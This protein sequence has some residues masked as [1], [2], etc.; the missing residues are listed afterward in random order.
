MKSIGTIDV[1]Q[2]SK[3]P[4]FRRL[5]LWVAMYILPPRSPTKAFQFPRIQSPYP[6]EVGVS[7][8]ELIGKVL[9]RVDGYDPKHR[10]I[11][12]VLEMR[13]SVFEHPGDVE[14][15]ISHAAAVTMEDFA[16][17]RGEQENASFGNSPMYTWTPS[18]ILPDLLRQVVRGSRLRWK[19][20]RC[21]F[22]TEEKPSCS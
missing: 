5:Q 17:E 3:R 4:R 11:P 2:L 1:L 19:H 10:G 18:I 13:S 21:I 12:K 20:A 9:I 6:P 22:N 16:L 14:L 8:T 15:T 7:P